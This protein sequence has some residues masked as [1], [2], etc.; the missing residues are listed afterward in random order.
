MKREKSVDFLP[1]LTGIRSTAPALLAGMKA[2]VETHENF[3]RYGSTDSRPA[4]LSQKNKYPNPMVVSPRFAASLNRGEN[5]L[6]GFHLAT[7]FLPLN[8][9][10]PFAKVSNQGTALR[11]AV[12][13]ARTE[14]GLW[15]DSLRKQAR[16]DE[17]TLRFCVGD[18]I[19]FAQTLQHRRVTGSL[20][21]GSWYRTR[22]ESFDPLV[23]NNSEYGPKGDAPVSFTSIDTS[24]LI[25]HA[26]PLNLLVAT[27]P[28]L[29]GA[30]CSTLYTESLVQRN[31]TLQKFIQNLFG[32]N[33]GF[34]SLVLGL[35]P[36]DY[37]TNT[38]PLCV[39]DEVMIAGKTRRRLGQVH[40]RMAWKRPPR[41]L[42]ASRGMGGACLEHLHMDASDLARLLFDVYLSMFP[43]ENTVNP[44]MLILGDRFSLPVYCRAN[45]ATLLRF[46]KSRVT[47]DW[48]TTVDQLIEFITDDTRRTTGPN[49]S[50]ELLMYMHLLDVCRVPALAAPRNQSAGGG[51]R[52]RISDWKD[53][54]PIVCVTLK[55]P[56]SRLGF[57][58]EAGGTLPV[59][60]YLQDS[61]GAKWHNT[62]AALQLGFGTIK[63][64]GTPYTS[65]FSLQIGEDPNGWYGSSDL[66]VTFKAPTWI[67]LQEPENARVVFCLHHSLAL[68]LGPQLVVFDAK[69]GDANHV[70]ITQEPPNLKGAATSA[71]FGK[72]DFVEPDLLNPGARTI[73]SAV[74]NGRSTTLTCRIDLDCPRLKS[75]LSSGCPVTTTASSVCARDVVMGDK[76]F[77]I[78]FPLPMAE[79]SIQTRI[80]RK[81]SYIEITG[82]VI[83]EISKTPSC[84]F[85]YPMIL[86]D[87]KPG[88]RSAPA[89]WNM[90]HVNLSTLPVINIEEKN[91]EDLSWVRSHLSHMWSD[92]EKLVSKIARR[93]VSKEERARIDFKESLFNMFTQFAGLRASEGA[94]LR[95]SIF[96][97]ICEEAGG[98]NMVIFVSAMHLDLSNRTLVLDA[99]VMP[100]TFNRAQQQLRVIHDIINTDKLIGVKVTLEELRLWKEVLPSMV[101][102]CRE[103][104][105]KEGCEYL[106]RGKPRTPPLSVSTGQRII[107]DCGLGCF[108]RD[109][110]VGYMRSN[111]QYVKRQCV[112]VAISPM[113]PSP[114]VDEQPNLFNAW[115]PLTETGTRAILSIFT[116]LWGLVKRLWQKTEEK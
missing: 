80:A 17:I 79:S 78:V 61:A 104:E 98:I 87:A 32:T 71:Y 75:T 59:Q 10:S 42:D 82:T 9:K 56:R 34:F 22:F 5:P 83:T 35:F 30:P 91:H 110:H 90:P 44:V 85:T 102:R 93:R 88:V 39:G 107:C 81:S 113:F 74:A 100:G 20:T 116:G 99:A 49:F 60:C 41:L 27:S 101:E 37:W 76:L 114:M 28:L 109:Y 45:F 63:T 97:L 96:A 8:D 29:A 54:P 103:W 70:S 51:T 108:P 73:T 14:F 66:L 19:A 67:L 89:P 52:R 105:H 115:T 65:T 38:T 21:T 40:T 24:N 106:A 57:F 64:T 46:V 58:T 13:A 31:Q 33:L 23:L 18:G 1:H 25:D 36:V 92:H 16:R 2:I 12:A 72:E 69:L 50:H 94:K 53:M 48:T 62:F 47:T 3:W 4:N 26:G 11:K 84:S 6:L 15:L 111:W 86:S 68:I 55:V 95:S 112:R 43:R 77:K 7:A